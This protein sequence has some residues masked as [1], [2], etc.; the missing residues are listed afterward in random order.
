MADFEIWD[1]NFEFFLQVFIVVRTNS[2]GGKS[3]FLFSHSPIHIFMVDGGILPAKSLHSDSG[4]PPPEEY[5]D[6][7]CGPLAACA[8][9]II[10][11]RKLF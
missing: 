7:H 3:I 10:L 9:Q 6:Q 5:T 8:D 2:K 1:M 11:F 4:T